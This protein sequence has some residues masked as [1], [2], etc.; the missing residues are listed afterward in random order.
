M[1]KPSKFIPTRAEIVAALRDVRYEIEALLQAP[2]HDPTDESIVETVFFR[3]MAHAR[4]LHTFFVTPI[5]ERYKDDVLA[6]DY[7]FQARAI[8]SDE[9]SQEFIDRFNKD[10]FHISYSRVHRT[11]VTKAWPMDEML[12]PI[13]KRSRE[14]IEH[15]LALGWPDV[16]SNE[17]RCWQAMRNERFR[18]TTLAQSTSNV[19]ASQVECVERCIKN[20]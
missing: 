8:Y 2:K 11:S 15:V 17:L 19:A 16:T 4:A 18:F 20:I 7:R 10:L 14:F 6:E 9:K 5:S 1:S 3:R 13:I 12:P